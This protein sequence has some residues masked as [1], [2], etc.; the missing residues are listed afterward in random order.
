VDN[1]I[2]ANLTT[3]QAEK[4][5]SRQVLDKSMTLDDYIS[6]KRI[7]GSL[8]ERLKILEAEDTAAL[9][10]VLEAANP[11][12]NTLRVMLTL[13]DEIC[14]REKKK[15]RDVLGSGGCVKIM[16][17]E[18]LS[19]KEKQK[20]IRLELEAIRYPETKKVRDKLTEAQEQVWAECGIKLE[21]PQDL[22]G[23]SVSVDLSSQSPGDFRRLGEKLKLL[24]EHPATARVFKLLRGE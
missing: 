19:R 16:E 13:V 4:P 22:E 18:K 15:F 20:R 12:A 23:D 10:F 2:S 6:E 14:S 3:E 5:L 1:S 17:N 21:L 8:L 24:A 9:L 11:S 7:S